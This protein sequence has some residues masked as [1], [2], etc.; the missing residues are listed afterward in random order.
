MVDSEENKLQLFQL[1]GQVLQMKSQKALYVEEELVASKRRGMSTSSGI[2]GLG[3]FVS[4]LFLTF[5]ISI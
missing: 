3:E 2:G 1:L 4:L 5:S